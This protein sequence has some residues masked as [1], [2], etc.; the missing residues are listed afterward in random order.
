MPLN[1]ESDSV[2]GVEKIKAQLDAFLATTTGL[3]L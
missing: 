2:G 1:I 3:K